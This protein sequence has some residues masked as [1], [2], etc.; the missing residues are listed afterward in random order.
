M[1]SATPLSGIDL[2]MPFPE[3][4]VG[5]TVELA[6]ADMWQWLER[7]ELCPTLPTIDHLRRTRPEIITALYIPAADGET[8]PYLSEWMAWFFIVDD[9]FDHSGSEGQDAQR[10][11][12]DIDSLLRVI[13]TG[14]HSAP[15]LSNGLPRAHAALS[16]LWQRLPSHL[17][18][19]WRTVFRDHIREWLWSDYA[20][21]VDRA[22]ERL[23]AL[24][25]YRE[26]RRD[27]VG[28]FMLLDLC[29]IAAGFEVTE[30]TR[31][32]PCMI[33]LRRSAVEHTG[34]I[35]DIR[36]VEKE[37]ANG[38]HRNTVL[39]IEQNHRIAV[40]SALKVAGG[41]A[42]ECIDRMNTARRELPSQLAAAGI[43]GVERGRALTIADHYLSL[44][45]GNFD[46]HEQT[47]RFNIGRYDHPDEFKEGNPVY[48]ADVLGR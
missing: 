41:F 40:D 19:N 25:E 33:N 6:A 31:R 38:D 36:S 30:L 28:N 14:A 2:S 39:L 27:N 10:C 15:A 11:A 43:T 47:E 42:N 1:K 44:V 12:R 29:E 24:W 37:R 23:P 13:D 4:E 9:Q 7:F 5:A 46:Y 35:N 18:P 17:S 22:S 3:N 26:H 16:D 21:M 34:I 20:E 48:L 8:L 45:R 32:L